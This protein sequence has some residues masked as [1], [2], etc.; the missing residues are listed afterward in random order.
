M[1]SERLR[2]QMEGISKRFGAT[3]ALEDV[4]LSVFRGEVHALVGENGAGKSTLMKILS[5]AYHP[6]AGSI[7]LDGEPYQ[8]SGPLEGRLAGIAM[9]YQ[10]LSL[11]PHLSIEENILLG[12]EPTRGPF[13]RRSE[14]RRIALDAMQQLGLEH[15]DPRLS[16]SALS[17][18]EQQLVEL[19][20]AVAVGCRV[21]VLDEPTSTLTQEDI[22]RLFELIRTLRGRGYAIVYISHFLEEVA[23][24]SDRFTVLRDGRVVGSGETVGVTPAD[25]ASLMVGRPI[26]DLYPKA[27]RQPGDVV[28]EVQG[29][30]GPH[31]PRSASLDLRRGEVLGIAGLIG[32][33][34]TEMLRTIFGLEPVRS[35]HVRVGAYVGPASPVRRWAQ[36]VGYLSEDRKQEGLALNLTLADNITLTSLQEYGPFGLVLPSRQDD[37]ARTWIDRLSIRCRNPR[38]QVQELSGGNQQK[39]ALARLLCH[40]VDLLLLD[41]PTRGIDVASK[42]EIYRLIDR[43]ATGDPQTGTEAKS[44]LIVSSYLPELL[45]VCDRI[46]VMCR[47]VLRPARSVSTLTEHDIMVEATGTGDLQ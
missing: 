35:G 15:L 4:N 14:R 3:I 1:P 16:V 45:G 24:I 38:Q 22:A 44:I 29:L 19:A 47:G 42:A 23:E 40:D 26:S 11:A 27:H 9:I 21:L 28:L 33:G 7:R 43:L 39:I 36:G 31:Y 8:P 30:V 41:E 37:V 18:A 17:I 32:A 13:I 25:L 34:R 5:G 10:E 2:L 20:R 46:A 12:I 6:D